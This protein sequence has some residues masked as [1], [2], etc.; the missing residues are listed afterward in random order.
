MVTFKLY[1]ILPPIIMSFFTEDTLKKIKQ[2]EVGVKVFKNLFDVNFINDLNNFRMNKIKNIIIREDATKLPFTFDSHELLIKLDKIIKKELGDF[3]VNDFSPHF[4]TSKFPLRLHADTGKDPHDVIGQNILIPINIHPSDKK[5]HTI[6]FKNKWYGPSAYFTTKNTDGHDHVLKDM[7]DNFID[8]FD[9]REFNEKIKNHKE[10]EI[11]EFSGGSFLI[12]N[13][14]K[15]QILKLVNS[16]RYNIRTNKHITEG[17]SFDKKIYEK[18]FSHQPYEDMDDLEVDT[19]YEWKLGDMIIWDRSRIHSSDNFLIDGLI[20]KT[21]I[22]L[23]GSYE[24]RPV[25][26]EKHFF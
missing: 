26:K 5:P 22:P 1:S 24:Y 18:Y 10:N 13:L 25:K 4:I 20:E 8:I 3:Y 23:F 21:A 16:R 15:E 6:I 9:I 14:F 19:I 12:N 7:N 11:I 2:K 17:K